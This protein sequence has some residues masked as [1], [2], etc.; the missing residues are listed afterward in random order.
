MEVINEKKQELAGS[1]DKKKTISTT[2]TTVKKM[3][4]GSLISHAMNNIDSMLPKLGS[5]TKMVHSGVKSNSVS[6][7]KEFGGKSSFTSVAH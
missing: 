2:R 5:G 4:N 3:V 1:G 6:S 7:N